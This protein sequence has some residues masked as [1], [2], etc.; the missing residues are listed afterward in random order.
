MSRVSYRAMVHV[1]RISQDTRGG[2]LIMLQQ[3]GVCLQDFHDVCT[4]KREDRSVRGFNNTLAHSCRKISDE[5]TSA[6]EEIRHQLAAMFQN[7]Y[8][9]RI[10]QRSS[11]I[12]EF[13]TFRTVL[14]T[15]V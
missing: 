7:G 15:P 1:I 11:T 14:N 9:F 5:N 13:S 10:I 8:S 12:E 4:G 6:R 2:M 3:Q